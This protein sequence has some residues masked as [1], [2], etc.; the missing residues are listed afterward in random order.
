MTSK[1]ILATLLFSIALGAAAKEPEEKPL[2]RLFFSPL[3]RS[4]RE[5]LRQDANAPSPPDS[6]QTIN[7]EVRRSSGK[8]TRWINGLASHDVPDQAPV[9]IGESYDLH[10]GKRESLLRGGRLDIRSGRGSP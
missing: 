10:Q 2:G 1:P 9:A 6:R 4:E 7:G 3:Q 5:Q 8:N